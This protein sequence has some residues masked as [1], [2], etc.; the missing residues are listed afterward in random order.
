M[1]FRNLVAVFAAVVTLGGVATAAAVTAPPAHAIVNIGNNW[2]IGDTSLCMNAWNGGPWVKQYTGGTTPNGDFTWDHGT[3]LP[4]QY[5]VF[6]NYA[7]P[8]ANRCIGDANNDAGDARAS[9]DVCP[10]TSGGSGSGDGWGTHI[11]RDTAS[12]A[13]GYVAFKDIHWNGW[14][15]PAN[16]TDNGAQY[17][18]NKQTPFCFRA[19]PP[20]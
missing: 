19:Y 3:A 5:L 13:N 20:Q 2:C 12:C 1:R 10:G 4:A 18:L 8:W 6:T 16:I 9:L 15:G 17:Y 14:I 7:S 11:L